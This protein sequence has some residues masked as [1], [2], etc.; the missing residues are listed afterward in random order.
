MTQP[1]LEIDNLSVQ[2]NLKR[3]VLRAIDQISFEIGKG[4]T[5][6]LVGESGSGKSVT[7][8]AIMRLIPSP[9]GEIATGTVRFQGRDLYQMPDKEIREIRGQN[10]AMVFQEPMNAL[11]PV[12]TVGSQIGD[13]LRTNMGMSKQ[14][15]RERTIEMLQLVGIPSPNDRVDNYVHEFSGGMRQR[16]MLAMALSCDP[17]FLIADEPTTALDVTIQAVILELITSMIERFDMSLLFIT[18]NLGVV[19]H[20]CDKIGVMYASHIVEVGTKEEIFANPQHPYTVGL[21]RSIPRLDVQSKFLTP[22]DGTVC[23][24]ME[25]PPGC[26]FNPRCSHAMDICRERI[27]EFK[28]L[29]PGHFAACHLHDQPT[30]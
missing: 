11:N 8:R 15:A 16:V 24:M 30:V 12:F 1:V 29:S 19:A 20:A 26:K 13:A 14:E 9:P 27:P 6:G 10:I 23:N 7:A 28:E 5:F 22:I 4:E 21:L 17:T 18:H 2:F 3:G 25:P